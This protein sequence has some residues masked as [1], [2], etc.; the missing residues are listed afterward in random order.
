MRTPH[1]KVEP[2]YAIYAVASGS[3]RADLSAFGMIESFPDRL[4]KHYLVTLAK[5]LLVLVNEG[6]LGTIL[7]RCA[8]V[9]T[10]V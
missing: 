2:R 5:T 9:E 8:F 4:S 10:I 1:G 3:V 7:N 6:R